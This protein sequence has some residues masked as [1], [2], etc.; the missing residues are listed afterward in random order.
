MNDRKGLFRALATIAFGLICAS[1]QAQSFPS[2]PIS[3]YL[4]LPAGGS[5]DFAT[6]V[7]AEKVGSL[8]GQRILVEN[9]PG[10][11]GVVAGNALRDAKPDGY[12]LAIVTSGTPTI[13]VHTRKLPFDPLEDF[14][15]IARLFSFPSFLAVPASSPANSV[16]DLVK[17]AKSSPK[18]LFYG[19]Q[20]T[21]S[22][23][24][25]MGVLFQDTVGAKLTNV[26][27]RGGPDMLHDLTSGQIDLAFISYTS[28]AGFIADGRLKV[29]ATAA[30]ARW[31]GLPNILTLDELGYSGVS[32]DSIF[33]LMGPKGMEPSVAEKLRATFAQ[34]L[35]DP[36]VKTKLAEQGF[37]VVPGDAKEFREFLEVDSKRL[38]ALISKHGLREN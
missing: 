32:I 21:G 33:G 5:T 18:G 23:Q 11:S 1:A 17:L 9:K 19:S 13:L 6:R 28:A 27:Y 35:A 16:A 7:L 38:G 24:W 22:P 37:V 10:A 34:A 26:A 36:S 29:L 30:P 12:T 15:L 25:L 2:K 4:G 3:L 20:G 8:L 31:E 14:T